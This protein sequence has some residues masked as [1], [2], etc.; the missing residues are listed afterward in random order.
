MGNYINDAWERI[1]VDSKPINFEVTVKSLPTKGNLVYEYNPFRNYRLSKNMYEYKNNIFSLEELKEKYYLRIRYTYKG[2]YIYD[3]NGISA[4]EILSVQKTGVWVYKDSVL[5]DQEQPVLREAG[6][7]VDFITDELSVSLEHPVSILPQHSYDGSVNL[8]LNDGLNV[9][10]MINSRFSATGRNT[11]EIVDRKGNNDTN[12]YDQGDQFDIDT[13]LLKK[14]RT[15]P[16][17]TY[18]GTFAGGRMPIGNYHFYF[19]KSRSRIL[20]YICILF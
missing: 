2:K 9:P 3:L 13:S 12:I 16:E 8:I 19:K 7:L 4:E 10:R 6:E 1:L 5:T 18:N 15:L 20:V 14:T 11:Y 17:L